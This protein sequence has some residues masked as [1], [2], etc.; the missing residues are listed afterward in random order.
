M[1]WYILPDITN[2]L[3]LKL[4][5]VLLFFGGGINPYL[6]SLHNCVDWAAAGWPTAKYSLVRL[7]LSVVY[8]V[9]L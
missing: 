7:T 6:Y 8:P 2:Y 9:R 1:W 5:G 3:V 4:C